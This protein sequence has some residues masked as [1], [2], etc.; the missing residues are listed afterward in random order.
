MPDL[1]FLLAVVALV[2]ANL[3]ARIAVSRGHFEDLPPMPHQD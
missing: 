3:V 2:V 1:A